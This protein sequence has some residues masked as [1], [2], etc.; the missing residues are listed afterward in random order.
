MRY[1]DKFAARQALSGDENKFLGGFA[2]FV[3][4]EKRPP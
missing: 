2:F 3:G 4:K 1:S